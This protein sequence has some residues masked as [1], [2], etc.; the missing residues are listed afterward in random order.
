[1]HGLGFVPT[2]KRKQTHQKSFLAFGEGEEAREDFDNEI[3]VSDDEGDGGRGYGG[4]RGQR[5]GLRGRGSADRRKRGKGK[6]LIR[7]SAD[8]PTPFTFTAEVSLPTLGPSLNY[9]GPPPPPPPDT[10]APPTKMRLFRT[11]R[12]RASA[13]IPQRQHGLVTFQKAQ[14]AAQGPQVSSGKHDI[15]SYTQEQ[16]ALAAAN[17][18]EGVPSYR[19]MFGGMGSKLVVSV[20]EFSFGINMGVLRALGV[21]RCRASRA[22]DLSVLEAR[23]SHMVQSDVTFRST[24]DTPEDPVAEEQGGETAADA[25]VLPSTTS[26]DL[27]IFSMVFGEGEGEEEEEEEEFKQY[28]RPPPVSML[29]KPPPVPP[30]RPKPKGSGPVPPPR[31]PKHVPTPTETEPTVSAG[32]DGP[33]LRVKHRVSTRVVGHKAL[34]LVDETDDMEV[35]GLAPTLTVAGGE[36][37]KKKTKRRKRRVSD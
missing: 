25:I 8:A 28:L 34:D 22:P 24:L 6:G 29:R 7:R 17:G 35:M 18:G 37:T 23:K 33:K 32:G 4:G 36:R 15:A 27:D 1:M 30:P 9:S 14:E 20:E 21:P 31:P 3:S 11:G 12:G 10:R 26:A 5:G 13:P 2:V 16:A 19:Q